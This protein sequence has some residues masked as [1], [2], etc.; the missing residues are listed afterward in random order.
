MALRSLSPNLPGRHTAQVVQR[1][2]R[3]L[4]HEANLWQHVWEAKSEKK[5]LERFILSAEARFGLK[6][7][8]AHHGRGAKGIKGSKGDAKGDEN[9]SR[10]H[11]GQDLVE[12]MKRILTLSAAA[13]EYGNSAERRRAGGRQGTA[14][15]ATPSASSSSPSSPVVDE[16]LR[17]IQHMFMSPALKNQPGYRPKKHSLTTFEFANTPT[18]SGTLVLTARPAWQPDSAT[19]ECPSCRSV[20]SVFNRRHHCRACGGLFDHKCCDNMVRI[21]SL[22]YDEPVRVCKFCLPVVVRDNT[23]RQSKSVHGPYECSLVDEGHQRRHHH[24]HYHHP[25]RGGGCRERQGGESKV[26]ADRPDQ[27]GG[28]GA[29]DEGWH[30]DADLQWCHGRRNS[31]APVAKR[32]LLQQSCDPAAHDEA[33]QRLRADLL[34]QHL[35]GTRREQQQQQHVLD[36]RGYRR[37]KSTA[38]DLVCDRF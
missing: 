32:R 34:R 16:A 27:C 6:K 15:S 37:A 20:F 4:D 26:S 17:E 35:E 24:H 25:R 12:R 10:N 31:V 7:E 9:H 28:G 22:R 36:M 21:F 1:T 8:S 5:E 29:P 18:H 14:F 33:E 11:I 2:E 38:V 19:T 13:N 23:E 30:L 3:D